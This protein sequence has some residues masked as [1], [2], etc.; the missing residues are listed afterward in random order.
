M[1]SDN[2]TNVD[3]E[4]IFKEDPRK[5]IRNMFNHPNDPT[6]DYDFYTDDGD[7]F[8]YYIV[9]DDGPLN[10]KQWGDINVLLFARGCLKTWSCTSLIAWALDMYDS[11]EFTATAPRDDQREEVIDNFKDR[12]QE[13][14]LVEQRVKDNIGHQKFEKEITDTDGNSITTHSALKSRSAWGDG[15][16]LRGLHSQGGVIDESQDVDEG[17]FSTFMEAIDQSI[18]DTAYFPSI[19]VIGTP[20][21]ANSFFH[22]LWKMSDQKTWSDEDRE[23]IQQNEPQEFLPAELREEKKELQQ[24]LSE[25]KELED[26]DSEEDYSDL[27]AE[28][29]EQLDEL[30]GYEVRGWH[31]DQ[32]NCPL[33]KKGAIN[34]KKETYSKQKFKNEVLAEFYSPENDLIVEDDVF[35]SFNKE[36]SFSLSDQDSGVKTVMGVD[37][38]GGDSEGAASTAIV[39]ADHY[40]ETDQFIVRYITTL[41]SSFSDKEEIVEVERLLNE[42]NVDECVVD[43]GYGDTSRAALQDG[44]MTDSEDGYSKRVH[45]CRYG[46]VKNKDEIKWNRFQSEY[47]YF[48][49]NRTYII[50]EF[51]NDFKRQKFELP[52]GDLSFDSNHDLGTQL[53]DQLTAPY[54]DRVETSSGKKKLKIQSDRNDDIFHAFVY[55]YLAAKRVNLG[56]GESRFI[57]QNRTG[58]DN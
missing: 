47:R 36:L 18:P 34:F 53:L 6:R 1:S 31:I 45:G 25:I 8:L 15:D 13:S 30:D 17:T 11:I 26:A 12:I 28:I 23:W 14:G 55:M 58:Y 21:M 56:G 27:K 22:K 41:D 39:I 5:Y 19:F 16:A 48:T 35:E 24:Q 10:P 9:D 42:Y 54:S 57:T 3:V 50:K 46:N 52:R 29:T 44:E 38:G 20:K 32:Y 49:C 2:D 4:D 51:T 37:W 7:E 43:E 40:D 33:H